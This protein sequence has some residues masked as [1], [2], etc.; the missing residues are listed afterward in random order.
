MTVLGEQ[1]AER[2]AGVTIRL[3]RHR[4]RDGTT[5]GRVR[6]SVERP[7]AAVVVGKRGSGK[8][9]TLGVLAEGVTDAPG[10]AATVVDPM[11]EFAGIGDTARPRIRANAVPARV[12][13][14]LVGVEPTSAAGGLVW[15]AVEE[16]DTLTGALAWLADS[17]AEQSAVRVA[18][19]HLR[20]A[21]RWGV[22]DPDGTS[23]AAFT[24]PGTRV[25]DCAG[26]PPPAINA[27]CRAVARACY[28]RRVAGDGERLPWLFVDEAHVPFG[29]VA[30]AGL[31][32]LFT[33]GRT[34][35]VSLVCA[36][37][38][39]TAVPA[40]AVSQADLLVI[41]QLTSGTD[42]QEALAARPR[43][44]QLESRL[45]AERGTAVV[46][47]DAT[48]TSVSVRVRDRRTAAGGASPTAS[49]FADE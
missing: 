40:V 17:P 43:A 13:P 37:Q 12:W 23:R 26:L 8:S 41:H 25:L 30:Q 4:A 45:P 38:R 36:T 5:G 44:Q 20:R 18:H 28:E 1:R 15:Q 48:E 27:V 33:R 10:V 32:R 16:T 49:A 29:G 6:L 34:P 24:R 21:D 7:H 35:G 39:P 9:H 11:G 42:V 14:A 31:R 3:G 2:T 22:F 47:D 19:N 46:V